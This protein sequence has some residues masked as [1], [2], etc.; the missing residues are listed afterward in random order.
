M[1]R[2]HV[3]M[4]IWE[5]ARERRAIWVRWKWW[6]RIAFL[7]V[8][9]IWLPLTIAAVIVLFAVYMLAL[10]IEMMWPRP[11]RVRA[12]AHMVNEDQTGRLWQ[13]ELPG[14]R[15]FMAVEVIDATP[16][17]KK[18]KKHEHFLIG[19]PSAMSTAKQAVAWTFKL[20]PSEYAPL[21]EA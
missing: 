3:L 17:D 12:I 7:L 6:E 13:F 14:Y 15:R 16:Y 9:P 10:G 18:L 1:M 5:W 4:P 20:N 2:L 8:T 19:V 11:R 21:V